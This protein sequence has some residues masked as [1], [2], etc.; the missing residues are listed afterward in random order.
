MFSF[1]ELLTTSSRSSAF[2][3]VETLRAEHVNVAPTQITAGRVYKQALSS[4]T[5]RIP[6]FV[7]ETYV[8]ARTLV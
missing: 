2:P 7:S 1:D 5:R 8:Q 3:E 4:V 6:L